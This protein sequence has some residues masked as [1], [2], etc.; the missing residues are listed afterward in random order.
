[1]RAVV[2]WTPY[3][4]G[5]RATDLAALARSTGVHVVAATGL[6]Q[7]AQYASEL[8]RRIAGR[9]AGLF[10]TELTDGVGAAGA[11]AGLIKVTGAVHGVDDHARSTM[12]A[13][14]EAHHRTGRRS[15]SIWS[16]GRVRSTCWSIRAGKLEVDP[17]R[18]ILCHPGRSPD[19]F[20]QREA[21][22]ARAFRAF[23]GPSRA[24]HATDRRP[25]DQLAALA[26][27]GFGGQVL[28]GGDTTVPGTPG[29][30][31]LLRRL[32]PRPEHVLGEEWLDAVL[33]GNPGRAFAFGPPHPS[34][35]TRR[36]AV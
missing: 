7:A 8:L 30:P 28:V 25:P 24:H 23:D 18:V 31:Y 5:R 1:M 10:V 13:A 12:T 20:V 33:V 11:R 29:M 2:Q 14:A 4:M 34:R 26:D 27:A 21:A 6:H 36:A 19:G 32:R 9:L 3:G 22:R 15:R 17:R 35:G 16:W